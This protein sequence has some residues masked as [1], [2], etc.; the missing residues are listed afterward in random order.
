MADNEMVDFF[1]F[2]ADGLTLTADGPINIV[3]HLI[4]ADT[5]EPDTKK[6]SAYNNVCGCSCSFRE[7]F[8]FRALRSVSSA[9]VYV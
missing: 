7:D 6:L 2:T 3:V 5:I 4:G 1:G 9:C 8:L